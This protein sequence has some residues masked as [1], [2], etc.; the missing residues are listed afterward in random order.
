[1]N[2][3]YPPCCEN[4]PK[5]DSAPHNCE[6]CENFDDY[7][8]FL[9]NYL[10]QS[11]PMIIPS[12]LRQSNRQM[13]S[14]Y[15]PQYRN[16]NY[17]YGSNTGS[18]LNQD[19]V[20][21]PYYDF[22]ENHANSQG[23]QNSNGQQSQ[24]NVN[25]PIH[26]ANNNSSQSFDDF[27]N[28]QR[29]T[30]DEQTKVI[31]DQTQDNNL[32][33]NE[34]KERIE[35][36]KTKIVHLNGCAYLADYY[37]NSTIKYS[38]LFDPYT[39]YYCILLY[40]VSF[41]E[42]KNDIDCLLI[43]VCHVQYKNIR[44]F[45]NKEK[46]K[47]SNQCFR[48]LRD[49]GVV[50]SHKVKEKKLKEPLFDYIRSKTPNRINCK[51]MTG[52]DIQNK[53]FNQKGYDFFSYSELH[54][55]KPQ[56]MDKFIDF[57]PMNQEGVFAYFEEYRE[58]FPNQKTRLLMA[59]YPF[60][61]LLHSL[62]KHCKNKVDF[63]LNLLPINEVITINYAHWFQIYNRN[64]LG[65]NDASD[66]YSNLKKAFA[67]SADDV[68]IL[69]A[70]DYS[71]ESAQSKKNKSKNC[72]EVIDKIPNGVSLI[73]CRDN[74]FAVVILSN[75]FYEGNCLRK[76]LQIS[77]N[78]DVHQRFINF[79][80]METVLNGVVLYIENFFDYALSFL[81]PVIPGEKSV[82][83]TFSA[84]YNLVKVI[85]QFF[86][87]SFTEM[88][89]LPEEIDFQEWFSEDDDEGN[90]EQVRMMIRKMCLSFHACSKKD[91]D[92]AKIYDKYCV[93]YDDE[94][95]MIPCHLITSQMSHYADY[96]NAAAFNATLQEL[97]EANLL[98]AGPGETNYRK[99][100]IAKQ[101]EAYY[102]FSR[103]WLTK[104]YEIDIV[105]K[106]EDA[107]YDS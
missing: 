70:L 18:N 42:T 65:L 24:M 37:N 68:V 102:W 99:I 39:M 29:T 59:L 58:Q 104:Y 50:F 17:N 93:Y 61:G 4:C 46:I 7:G 76:T 57:V 71:G 48:L 9:T 107:L 95:V 100:Q 66:K 87:Y 3:I 97:K 105:L 49:A 92:E 43:E 51:S 62:L 69:N 77:Y 16:Q 12:S 41:H 64:Y 47:N 11:Q 25:V 13:L 22:E 28:S 96:I 67:N 94:W 84:V 101:R 8:R 81:H 106:M 15:W 98:K 34:P 1:M 19:F 40:D 80:A 74:N 52:W 88:M 78:E 20:P 91:A 73:D 26:L 54:I 53:A 44:I 83:S 6:G 30:Q 14:N 45:V 103:Q 27:M 2:L 79:K 31:T 55:Q 72:A 90:T 5:L 85:L 38:Q 60:V 10:L 56:V 75:S 86:G 63:V 35:I 36:T 82:P 89:G 23:N 33:N 32:Q 21:N